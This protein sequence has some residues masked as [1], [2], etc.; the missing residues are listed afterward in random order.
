MARDEE[1]GIE[2]VKQ[3]ALDLALANF[4]ENAIDPQGHSAKA[5]SATWISPYMS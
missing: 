4:M 3:D 5:D 2:Q 1:M